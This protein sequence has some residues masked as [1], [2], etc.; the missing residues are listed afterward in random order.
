MTEADLNLFI[1]DV[2]RRVCS[3]DVDDW[4]SQH[5]EIAEALTFGDGDDRTR[6]AIGLLL[7]RI[8]DYEDRT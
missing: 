3:L 7:D 4:V 8:A 2:H 6:D 5:W 1:C